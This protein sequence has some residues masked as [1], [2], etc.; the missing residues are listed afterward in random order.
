MAHICVLAGEK[1][2]CSCHAY[3]RWAPLWLARSCFL[4]PALA[5]AAP[6]HAVHYIQV[7]HPGRARSASIL[8]GASAPHSG[9]TRAMNVTR[10]AAHA[11]IAITAL[12]D[13]ANAAS[14]LHLPKFVTLAVPSCL[15]V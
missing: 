6:V 13:A 1:D 14:F 2:G 3:C 15:R 7:A 9:A 5:I 11:G 4:I 12:F 8:L 10:L